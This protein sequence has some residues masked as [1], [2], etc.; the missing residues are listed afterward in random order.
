MKP[1]RRD[2]VS[3][4]TVFRRLEKP[5]TLVTGNY[6]VEIGGN[7]VKGVSTLSTST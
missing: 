1:E 3:G 7:S 6:K 4:F 2:D 5:K